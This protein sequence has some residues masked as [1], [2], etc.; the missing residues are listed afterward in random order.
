MS[1]RRSLRLV[2]LIRLLGLSCLL[3]VVSGCGIPQVLSPALPDSAGTV[4]VGK[5]LSQPFLAP[6]D[7]LDGITIAASPPLTSDGDLLPN[8]TGGA[9]VSIR[10]APEADARFP[11]EAFHDWP[12]TDQW[13]GELTGTQQVGQSFLSRYPGLNGITLRVATYGAD[14]GTGDGLLKAGPSVDVLAFPIDGAVIATIDGGSMVDVVGAAE[15][16]AQISFGDKRIGYLPFSAFAQ[17]PPSTRKNTHDVV[18]T[19][20]R[21]SDMSKVRTVT[22]NAAQLHDNSH[23]SF[24]FQPIADSDGQSYR[25]VL[26][27]PDS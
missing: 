8:P 2:D 10:Y 5:R 14:T 4:S 12:A 11:E 20:Y 24:Q 1:Q 22:I 23:V 19:L 25:F 26:T 3:L 6:S 13:L 18:L 27:S 15:G 21:E 9:T 16:W 7:G 17:L